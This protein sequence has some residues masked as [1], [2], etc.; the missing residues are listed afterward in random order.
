MYQ[1]FFNKYGS[2]GLLFDADGRGGAGGGGANDQTDWE[3]KYKEL[4]EKIET[5]Y[6]A[7]S[8]YAALQ[9][10]L[11]KA[12]DKAKALEGDYGAAVASLTT[13]ESS[14]KALKDQISQ[15]QGTIATKEGELA[16]ANSKLE[17]HNI[18]MKNYPALSEFEADGLLP[19]AP[20]D[21]LEGKLKTF[22]DKL[23]AGNAK[24]VDG[25][26]AGGEDQKPPKKDSVLPPSAGRSAEVVRNEMFAASKAGNTVEY[27]KLRVELQDVLKKSQ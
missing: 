3:A 14:E 16:K 17:R 21:Q 15:L 7:R 12:S 26:K 13:L 22:Y 8:A 24:A 5:D 11:Q 25:F 10:T 27:E 23:M 6:I 9:S 2:N 4:N 20:I 19:D 1:Q 18:I